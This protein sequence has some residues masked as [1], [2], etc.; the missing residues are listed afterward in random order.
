MRQAPNRGNKGDVYLGENAKKART[1]RANTVPGAKT[2]SREGGREKKNHTASIGSIRRIF[3]R[4]LPAR[5]RTIESHILM[6]RKRLTSQITF[7]HHYNNYYFSLT[8][9]TRQPAPEIARSRI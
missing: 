1:R 9:P 3:P 5:R 2:T 8:D 6:L 4:D 7:L